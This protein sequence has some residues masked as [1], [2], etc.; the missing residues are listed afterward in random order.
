MTTVDPIQGEGGAGEAAEPTNPDVTPQAPEGDEGA[1]PDSNSDPL[2]AITDEKER[3]EAKKHRAIARRAMKDGQQFDE[4]GNVILGQTPTPPEAPEATSPASNVATKDDLKRIANNQAKQL[5]SPEVREV[6]DELAKIPLAG[7]DS[8]DAE[9]IATNMLQRYTLYRE[10]NPIDPEDPAAPL[11]TSPQVPAGGGSK[12][13][14]KAAEPELP[15]YKEPVS[16]EDWYP[17]TPK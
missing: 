10:Q 14:K 15:G 6:W 17:E 7:F 3:A 8:S 5:V 11:Q 13:P 16:P 2:D 1:N 9:S 12:P 4:N